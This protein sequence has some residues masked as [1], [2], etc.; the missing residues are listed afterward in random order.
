MTILQASAGQCDQKINNA[1]TLEQWSKK[2][3]REG[4]KE[5]Y[6]LHKRIYNPSHCLPAYYNHKKLNMIMQQVVIVVWNPS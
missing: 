1:D 3:R 2:K 6:K 4:Y 5:I